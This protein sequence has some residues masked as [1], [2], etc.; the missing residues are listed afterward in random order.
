MPSLELGARKPASAVVVP[1]DPHL[2]KMLLRVIELYG[3]KQPYPSKV[4][5]LDSRRG[6]AAGRHNRHSRVGVASEIREHGEREPYLPRSREGPEGGQPPYL[7]PRPGG[8]RGPGGGGPEEQGGPRG[9]EE[10]DVYLTQ[11]GNELRAPPERPYAREPGAPQQEG[12]GQQEHPYREPPRPEVPRGQGGGGPEE[13]RRPTPRRRFPILPV[14]V[15]LA[16]LVTAGYLLLSSAPTRRPEP[17]R[18]VPGAAVPG[19]P[20][21]PDYP[22]LLREYD[23]RLEGYDRRLGPVASRLEQAAKTVEQAATAL[24]GYERLQQRPRATPTRRPVVRVPKAPD[25]KAQIEGLKTQVTG[26]GEEVKTGQRQLGDLTT[27]V[28][29]LERAKEGAEATRPL[30]GVGAPFSL[31]NIGSQVEPLN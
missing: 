31:E 26:L 17:A 22:A 20:V 6:G 11:L 2:E 3:T 30:E 8:P 5:D 21:Q 28:E 12:G 25:Y 13:P 15:V 4:I 29:Q 27:R 14:G 10:I 1:Q 19:A 23:K 18:A 9:Q 16:G 7:H 24:Q